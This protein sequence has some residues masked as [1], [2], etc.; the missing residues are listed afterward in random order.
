MT[1]GTRGKRYIRTLYVC[2]HA[3]MPTHTHAHMHASTHAFMHTCI[4]ACTHGHMHAHMHS[5]MHTCTHACTHACMH[6]LIICRAENNKQATGSPL[7]AIT[8]YLPQSTRM[9]LSIEN[10]HQLL[11][12]HAHIMESTLELEWLLASLHHQS[13]IICTVPYTV[14]PHLSA[15][16]IS[17]SLTFNSSLYWN[18]SAIILLYTILLLPHL[19]SSL[20]LSAILSTTNVCG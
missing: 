4:H 15:P 11:R 6:A 7:P 13:G 5:H 1:D 20:T 9:T 3:H 16:Q 10:R 17:S 8:I 14:R 18:K 2:T 19:S 12:C